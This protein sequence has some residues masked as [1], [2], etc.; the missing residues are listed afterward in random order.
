MDERVF[1]ST[2]ERGNQYFSLS[3]IPQ[4]GTQ[5]SD[6]DTGIRSY[7]WFKVRLHVG[8]VAKQVIVE[9]PVIQL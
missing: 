3:V 5:A 7:G 8:Q 2:Y 4:C 6:Q 1:Q 9:D